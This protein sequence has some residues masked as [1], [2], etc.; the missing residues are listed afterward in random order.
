MKFVE[1]KNH[2]YKRF[3][4]ELGFV[5]IN[6]SYLYKNNEV[7]III[8]VRKSNYSNVAYVIVGISP[9]DILLD[10]GKMEDPTTYESSPITRPVRIGKAV[11]ELDDMEFSQIDEDIDDF[12]KD[13]FPH[14]LS[15]EKLKEY[16]K[17]RLEEL[18]P[19][20]REFWYGIPEEDH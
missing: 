19:Y 7:S 11:Y 14:L 13:I 1:F 20:A 4:N 9:K 3:I 8:D 17:D 12:S 6:K 5:K 18:R 16:Y 10:N 15:I 2:I